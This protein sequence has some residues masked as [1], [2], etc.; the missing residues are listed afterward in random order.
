MHDRND[1]GATACL[2]PNSDV[3][4]TNECGTRSSHVDESPSPKCIKSRHF[5]TNHIYGMSYQYKTKS[6]KN[7][8]VKED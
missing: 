2:K 3:H 6:A 1:D 8:K 4:I 7:Y 5:P